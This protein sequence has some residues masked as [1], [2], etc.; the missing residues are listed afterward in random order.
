MKRT[1]AHQLSFFVCLTFAI[2]LL[3]PCAAL[4]ET[5][6]QWVAK[7]VSVEG[8]VD[9]QRS[10]ETQW[11][12]VKLDDTFCPGDTIRVDDRSRAALSLVNQPLIRIP[13]LPSAAC[14]KIEALS[15]SWPKAP[16]IFSA[17]FAATWKW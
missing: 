13:R 11:Q 2:T 3:Y 5:C 15:S 4:A 12:A 17:V 16:Y 1:T 8:N 14:K 10:G 7:A 6:Q 9:V